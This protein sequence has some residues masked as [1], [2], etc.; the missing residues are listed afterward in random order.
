MERFLMTDRAS[1]H[2][3]GTGVVSLDLSDI[4]DYGVL[5]SAL[6][7]YASTLRERADGARRQITQGSTDPALYEMDDLYAIANRADTLLQIIDTQ[8]KDASRPTD[9]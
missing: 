6:N 5:W 8:L 3:T 7:S 4:E 2:L 9:R 1:Q